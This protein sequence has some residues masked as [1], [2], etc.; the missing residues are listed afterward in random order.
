MMRFMAILI[1]IA[2][3]GGLGALAR[4]GS[5]ELMHAVLGMPIF[6]AL[7]IVNV[8]GSLAIGL[9]FGSLEGRYN[10]HGTSR[11]KTLP[12]SKPLHKFP[13]WLEE[14]PTLP[15]VDLL[16]FDRTLQMA[17]ALLITGFLGAYTT[18]S[19]L[20]LLTVHQLQT[21]HTLEAIISVVGSIT[22]GLIFVWYGVHIGCRMTT[23]KTS[24]RRRSTP[25][26]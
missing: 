6:I 3:G 5:M 11:L 16:R 21:G 10:Y 12:H 15:T 22:L 25:G 7:G 26:S 18:F 20:S 17:S 4:E 13:G 8:L 14:D 2:I 24:E 1:C 23:R 19:A 9:V